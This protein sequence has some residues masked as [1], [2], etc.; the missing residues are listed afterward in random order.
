MLSNGLP[1]CGQFLFACNQTKES[2]SRLPGAH[3]PCMSLQCLARSKRE[4]TSLSKSSLCKPQDRCWSLDAPSDDQKSV[5]LHS[6]KF[7]IESHHA[8][9]DAH[10]G[11][12]SWLK[13]EAD[14]ELITSSFLMTVSQNHIFWAARRR[15]KSL[16]GA[17]VKVCTAQV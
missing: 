11:P 15:C 16:P 12:T 10:H 5:S 2:H 17:G 4:V 1:S 3:S 14:I 9:G 8:T 13:N 6:M 7:L